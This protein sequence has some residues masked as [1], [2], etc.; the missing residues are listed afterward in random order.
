MIALLVIPARVERRTPRPDRQV[1]GR[2][3]LYRYMRRYAYILAPKPS[4]RSYDAH[5]AFH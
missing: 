3:G 4:N 5:F 1:R 2:M